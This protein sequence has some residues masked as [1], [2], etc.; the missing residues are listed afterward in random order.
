[1]VPS[2]GASLTGK[3]HAIDSRITMRWKTGE[4]DC[5]WTG[6]EHNISGRRVFHGAAT[7]YAT[8]YRMS[9]A[10]LHK[11]FTSDF[12]VCHPRCVYIN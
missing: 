12:E 4:N 9:A 1:M 2:Q 8:G 6:W 5:V 11:F 10:K 3:Y 7:F